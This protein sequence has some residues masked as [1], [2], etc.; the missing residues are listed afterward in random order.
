MLASHYQY[1]RPKDG[2]ILK[3]LGDGSSGIADI[4]WEEEYQRKI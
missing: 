4:I 1:G 3:I 2:Y